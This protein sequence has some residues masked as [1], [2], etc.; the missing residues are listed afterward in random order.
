M[1]RKVVGIAVVCMFCV[2]V[3]L[4][5]PVRGIITKVDGDKI[6]FMKTTFNKDTKTLEK[7]DAQVLTVGAD[8]KITGGKFNK[9]TKKLEAGDPLEGGLKNKLFAEIGEKG[10]GATVDIDG[11]A[12]KSIIA[13]GGK[14]K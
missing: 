3:V 5:E 6:T 11:K 1:F 9:D 8:C 12:A 2:G 10:V 7:G 4:A 13:G 14:G